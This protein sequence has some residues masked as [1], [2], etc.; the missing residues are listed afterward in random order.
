MKR[1]LLIALTVAAALMGVLAGG[2][3][4]YWRTGGSGSSAASVGAAQAVTI[5]AASG[6]PSSSLTPGG[7]AD[8]VVTLNNPNTYSVTITSVSQN[9]AVTPV[10]NGSCSAANAGVSVPSQNGLT[11]SI[12]P[13]SGQTVHIP[14]GTSMATG[15]TVAARASP[16]RSL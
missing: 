6:T 7:T 10:P 2:V 8:L 16:S 3:Y 11:I 12:A 15:Q 5:V 1:R 4:A 14:S 9:G 13:G